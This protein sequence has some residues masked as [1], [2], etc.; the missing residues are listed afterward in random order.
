MSRFTSIPVAPPNPV[1]GL[2]RE[3]QL[4]PSPN[5]INLTVG[6]YKDENG[7][8]CV[9]PSV[10]AAEGIVY[11]ENA[12]HE[13]LTQDGYA[14]F[15]KV[16]QE[17]LFGENSNI[18]NEKKVYTIQSISGTGSLRLGA[19]FL[20]TFYPNS[21]I[22]MTNP[23]WGNHPTIF[24]YAGMKVDYYRYLDSSGSALDFDGMITDL[25]SCPM[26]SIILLQMCA[27]NPTGV[28]PST[29]Q[30]DQI[31]DVCKERN[32]FPFFDN[33]YQGFVIDPDTDAYSVRTFAKK[34]ISM[35]AAC[36][37]SK[38]FG[39]YGERTGVLHAV[40]QN[41]DEI[42]GVG[43]QLRQMARPIYSTCPAF[44]ARIVATI[45]GDP[46]LKKQWLGECKAIADRMLGVRDQLYNEL[47]AKN[48]KGKWEHVKIQNG[49]FSYTG[50]N[51]ET[52]RRLKEVYHIYMLKSG[53]VNIAGLNDSNIHTFIDAL[54]SILG[55]N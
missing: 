6:A 54:L 31:A 13:Y 22:Y 38:N 20:K 28:D 49:M 16:A 19:E 47:V 30:W 17:L 9:L 3:C 42:I 15:L 45:L 7:K 25:K 24:Q 36:S 35:L 52:V 23:T 14:P 12:G 4:D 11:N 18:I 5:K 53:R 8:A 34:G 37:F 55:T 2:S 1:L 43:S 41:E 21:K 32:L 27:H 48:V 39:L 51:E 50:L 40:V 26:D 29:E 46:V 44:G 33:A 10:R